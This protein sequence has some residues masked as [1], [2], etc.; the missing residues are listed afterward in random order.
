M[1][2]LAARATMGMRGILNGENRRTPSRDKTKPLTLFVA[3][4]ENVLLDALFALR[5][6]V[7]LHGERQR[8]VF[9][10]YLLQHG[11]RN[12]DLNRTMNRHKRTGDWSM[13]Q[14]T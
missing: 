6:A 2:R 7:V 8:E 13:V 10:D 11:G 14:T 3:L 5:A 9:R 1:L 4:A 12:D